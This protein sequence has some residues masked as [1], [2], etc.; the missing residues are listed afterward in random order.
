[1]PRNSIRTAKV[2]D[3]ALAMCAGLV[4]DLALPLLTDSKWD[5]VFFQTH[6]F[7]HRV[8]LATLTTGET[9]FFQASPTPHVSNVVNPRTIVG[10]ES[11]FLCTG[12]A[13]DIQPQYQPDGTA[14][15]DGEPYQVDADPA[16]V[17]ADFAAILR[18]GLLRVRINKNERVYH[19]LHQFPFGGGPFIQ[20]NH[21]NTTATTLSSAMV[22]NNG[23]PDRNNRFS[24]ATPWPI[25]PDDPVEVALRWSVARALKDAYSFGVYL[26]GVLVENGSN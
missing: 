6:S 20:G 16:T 25:F 5:G 1:M 12:I 17:A 26:D 23:T 21:N 9:L 24:F 18:H 2:R 3:I 14:E 7:F 4:G 15:V 11:V 19:G 13:V 8:S 22:A 10:G